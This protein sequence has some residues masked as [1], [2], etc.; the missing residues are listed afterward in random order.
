MDEQGGGE[1]TMIQ[2]AATEGM[3]DGCVLQGLQRGGNCDESEE[4]LTEVEEGGNGAEFVFCGRRG[5]D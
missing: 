5:R 4:M 2:L 3:K 1:V